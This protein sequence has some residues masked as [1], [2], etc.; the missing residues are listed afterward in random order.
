[1]ASTLSNPRTTQ[2]GRERL[3]LAVADVGWYTTE[4]LF[5]EVPE[6]RASSLLLR[7]ADVRVAWSKGERP[8]SWNKPASEASPGLWEARPGPA[9]P[10]G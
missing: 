6:E 4:N 2:T 5:R 3:A 9:P 7:C 8:W 1:M 10:A